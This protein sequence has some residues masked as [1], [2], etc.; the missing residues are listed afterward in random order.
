MDNNRIFDFNSFQELLLKWPDS[1]Y[2][3]NSY[4]IKDPILNRIFQ[5]IIDHNDRELYTS[6]PDLLP[7][8]RQLLFNTGNNTSY[9]QLK[10]PA[11]TSLPDKKTWEEYSF[12]VTPI[13]EG[14]IL[15]PKPW[16]GKWL[17]EKN[18]LEQDIF[19][20]EF[21]AVK[22]RHSAEVP[23]DPFLN[24]LCGYNFYLCPGQREAIRSM[25][26]MPEGETLIV[27][28]PTGGGKSLVGQAPVL[29]RG[30][31]NGLTLFI[32]PTTALVIDL[33]RRM[34]DLLLKQ[35]SP[36]EIP[37]MAW[38]GECSEEIKKNIKERIR[39]G[40]QGI[41]F[42]SPE[43]VAGSLLPSLYDAVKKG[44]IKYLVV[45]E[46]HLIAQWGDSFRPA[47][48]QLSGIRKGLL[49]KSQGEKFRTIL[50]SATLSKQTLDTLNVLFA[51]RREIQMVS[52][53]HLRPEPRYFTHKVTNWGEKKTKVLELLKH[54]PRPF[55]LYV[56]ER[57]HADS[58]FRI[59]INEGYKR[60]ETFHGDTISSK[61]KKIIDQ[62]VNNKLDGIIATSAFGVG[63][64]KNDIRTVI[65][66]TVPETLDRYYQEVGRGGRDG[67]A[68]LSIVIYD[69]RDEATAERM[70]RSYVI[71]EDKAF[72]RWI[73][74][75][76][77]QHKR[78]NDLHIL[79]LNAV[80]SNLSQQTDFNNQW[81]MRTL[82]L[83][84]RSGIIEL[85]SFEPLSPEKQP[86]ETECDYSYRIEKFW[87]EFYNSV[88]VR[89]ITSHHMN[90]DYFFDKVVSER[91]KAERLADISF[92]N[93]MSTL[94]QEK[95]IS[96]AL[97]EL[98][99]N[100]NFDQSVLVSEVCRG[101][102]QDKEF[103][104]PFN[105]DYQ[106]PLGIGIENIVA[107]KINMWNKH[108]S[109]LNKVPAVILCP[110]HECM[111]EG[112][113]FK[114]LEVLVTMFGIK[115]ISATQNEWRTSHNLKTLHQRSPDK[116][117][118]SRFIE[119][120]VNLPEY[121]LPLP[122]ISLLT[123]RKNKPIPDFLLFM[124]R[125]LHVIIAPENIPSTHPHRLYKD[126]AV[127]YIH[128]KE[129]LRISTQ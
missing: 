122:R 44:L 84:A 34:K 40:R 28:L 109:W 33:N 50:M 92:N 4:I 52:A 61:R 106:I 120:D 80:P 31:E 93:L 117:L 24:E 49:N 90:K 65:H 15:E 78:E 58:W 96:D 18:T 73:T 1:S 75:Y 47:F 102:L 82:L 59:L 124:E 62:W 98:Y 48:Q 76:Q 8:I 88:S 107:P 119:D 110:E 30:I 126:D 94:R 2:V 13:N 79:D 105:V 25:L 41:L 38:F 22:V 128:L 103:T 72:D 87:N 70:S 17:T 64:D 125:P 32:V 69:D 20:A 39:N 7:L 35:Y 97:S 10:V 104:D 99:S 3:Q 71:S 53:V 60:I 55:I 29:L 21:K 51:P 77:A 118:I 113:L 74:M 63:M 111:L 89:T 6:Y 108:F 115:E 56:T 12:H 95:R 129:F 83:L 112:K 100:D 14:F 37:E 23:M 42:T 46:A 9:S 86:E 121:A 5:I 116:L 19:Q 54:V 85:D 127:N 81:N 123:S 36:D 27:N 114:A 11:K 26:F 57:K 43:G 66:A 91:Q 68:C 45:D 16:E 101:C 67:C